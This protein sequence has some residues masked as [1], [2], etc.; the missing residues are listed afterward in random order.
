MQLQ[1]ESWVMQSTWRQ[2]KQLSL[3]LLWHA[4]LLRQM[5]WDCPL[6]RRLLALTCQ[7]IREK[8]DAPTEKRER[9]SRR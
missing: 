1:L 5:Q 6:Q 3:R 2:R 7:K 8:R 4:V 9:R